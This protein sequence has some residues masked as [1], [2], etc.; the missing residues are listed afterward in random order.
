VVI[1]VKNNERIEYEFEEEHN[2]V[3]IELANAMRL[4]AIALIFVGIATMVIGIMDTFDILDI[5]DG[6]TWILMGVIFYLPINNF[7]KITK[8]EGSD[9]RELI[10]AFTLL[11]KGWLLLLFALIVNKLIQFLIALNLNI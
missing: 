2:Q 7:L 6:I 5:L 3:F 9:I 4:V 11:D 8:E 1:I 10:T